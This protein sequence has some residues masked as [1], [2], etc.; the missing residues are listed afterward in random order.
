MKVSLT[1]IL[2]SL[3][4]I[5]NVEGIMPR[6]QAYLA[7]MT[8]AAR[9]EFLPLGVFSPMGKRQA[10]YLDALI[11]LKAEDIATEATAEVTAKLAALPDHY[12]L[13]LVVADV[14]RNGWTERYLTDAEWRFYD[15]YN[16]LPKEVAPIDFDR[17]VTVQLWTD[18]ESTASY[19]RKE[20]QAAIY[21]AAHLRR[22]GAPTTLEA[23]IRQEGRALA[24]AGY[25]PDL[26]TD[27]ITYSREIIEPLRNSTD[28]ATC[29]GVLYGDDIAR[30]VGYQPLGL[31]AFAGINVGIANAWEHGSAEQWLQ[32]VANN[33]IQDNASRSEVSIVVKVG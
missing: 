24:F 32:G 13:L 30:A 10:D 3:R 16:Q 23:M 28:Q 26:D 18:E 12:R 6:F 25:A 21:R 29:F 5:Y 20:T 15:K 7:L 14:S 33:A 2:Q 31:S 1:P 4:D 11:K 22:L 19:I 27:D 9:G 17:W 8:G